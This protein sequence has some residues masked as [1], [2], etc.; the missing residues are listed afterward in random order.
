[1]ILLPPTPHFSYFNFE[2]DSGTESIEP[3]FIIFKKLIFNTN[4]AVFRF[5]LTGREMTPNRSGVSGISRFHFPPARSLKPAKPAPGK[6]IDG[7][8]RPAALRFAISGC[9]PS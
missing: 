9:E 8:Y 2:T 6:H 4:N 3:E 5:F 7:I 1:M